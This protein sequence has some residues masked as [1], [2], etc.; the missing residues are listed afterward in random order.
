MMILASMFDLLSYFHFL[1]AI[2]V[3]LSTIAVIEAVRLFVGVRV[4]LQT[5]VLTLLMDQ[6]CLLQGA[7]TYF[8]IYEKKKV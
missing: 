2:Q 3:F 8:S 5:F 6:F 4:R 7:C 1:L